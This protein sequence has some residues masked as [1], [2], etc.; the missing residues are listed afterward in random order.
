MKDGDERVLRALREQL[1]RRTRTLQGGAEAVGWKVA[2]GITPVEE[3]I[4]DRPIFG[5]LT[6]ESRL[7][8]DQRFSAQH[9]AELRADCELA[10]RLGRDIG[11]DADLDYVRGSVEGFA[12]A[13]ELV[14][15]AHRPGDVEGAVVS[16]VYH[17]AFAFGVFSD[18]LPGD[19]VRATLRVDGTV[20][21]SG[22]ADATILLGGSRP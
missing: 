20:R 2:L 22:E 18:D 14:D 12:T 1:Q 16:N 5:Y 4:G 7:Q 17:R 15:I 9:I 11:G 6:S 19:A 3:L 8:P 10:V 13:L 21:G